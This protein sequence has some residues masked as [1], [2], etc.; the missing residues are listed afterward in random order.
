MYAANGLQWHLQSL[1]D[2]VWH[3]KEEQWVSLGSAR[4]LPAT[5]DKDDKCMPAHFDGGRAF[6]VWAIGLWTRRI[7]R[8]WDAEEAM[9]EIKTFSGHTYFAGFMGPRH[10]VVHPLQRDPV[11]SS[12][13]ALQSKRCGPV[14]V[15]LFVRSTCFGHNKLSNSCRMPSE[16]VLV[17][18]LSRAV[19]AWQQAHALVLPNL[20]D[21][22]QVRDETLAAAAA[23]AGEKAS[24]SSCTY[25]N[26]PKA[27]PQTGKE[28]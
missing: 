14:E 17:R 26:T 23:A 6:L 4:G 18:A 28:Y 27:R 1:R 10:Q 7:V 16:K 2:V 5:P 13:D 20:K 11:E 19:V 12:P 9:Q 24:G 15:V 8:V 22:E 3:T 25:P 21:V